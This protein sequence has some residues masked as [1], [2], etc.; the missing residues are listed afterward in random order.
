M[1]GLYAFLG[2]IGQAGTRGAHVEEEMGERRGKM[3]GRN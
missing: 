2:Q 3:R 1:C